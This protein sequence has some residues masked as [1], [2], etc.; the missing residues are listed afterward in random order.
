[1]TLAK[2]ILDFKL[3][4]VGTLDS[5]MEKIATKIFNYPQNLGMP[6]TPNYSEKDLSVLDYISNSGLLRCS[7]VSNVHR[8]FRMCGSFMDLWN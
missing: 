3:A 6:I 2:K 1:M 4:F 8:L 7:H 5:L